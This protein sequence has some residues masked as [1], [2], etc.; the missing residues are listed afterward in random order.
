MARPEGTRILVREGRRG[1]AGRTGCPEPPAGAAPARLARPARFLTAAGPAFDW[2]SPP[3]QDTFRLGGRRTSPG[4]R[5]PG[6]GRPPSSL[7]DRA[8]GQRRWRVLLVG[9]DEGH[10]ARISN[11]LARPGGPG[12]DLVRVGTGA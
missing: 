5:R 3:S 10:L 4:Q 7:Q 12:G 9:G 8:M 11:L 2:L 1:C 6:S